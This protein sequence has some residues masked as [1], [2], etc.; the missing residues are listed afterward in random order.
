[1]KFIEKEKLEPGMI[2][3]KSIYDEKHTLLLAANRTLTPQIVNAIRRGPLEGLYVFDEYSSYEELNTIMNEDT[4]RK[5]MSELRDF[6]IDQVI[7][8]TNQIVASIMAKKDDLLVDLTELYSYDYGTYQHSMNVAMLSTTIGVGLGLDNQNLQYLALAGAL[9]DIGKRVI[10]KEI[11]NKPGKLNE[12]EQALMHNHPQFGYNMLY[13]NYNIS[14]FTRSAILAH[15][16]NYDGSGYPNHL[17]GE[18]IPLF[19]RII[20][21][22]DI[23]DALIQKRSYKNPFSCAEAIEYIMGSC[24]TLFDE[25]IVKTFLKYLVVYPVGSTVTLSTGEKAHVIKNRNHSVTRPVV[26]T[27]NKKMLDLANDPKCFNITIIS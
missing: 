23:Y 8:L 12:E 13:D 1:M 17:K 14:A 7:Y 20:H 21:I 24:G 26:I 11:L 4:R 18:N 25:D 16:E 10:P 19:G 27:E 22:A 5:T 2:S 6:N 9:H 15:H 3:T